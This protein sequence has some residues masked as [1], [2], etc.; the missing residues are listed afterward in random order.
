M[1]YNVEMQAVAL[2]E[3][4]KRARYY[5]SQLDMELLVTGREYSELPKAYVIFICDFDPFGKLKYKGAKSYG[6]CT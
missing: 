2:C 6:G 3:L 5:H 1:H 4:G